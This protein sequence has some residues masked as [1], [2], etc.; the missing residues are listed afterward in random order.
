MHH[1]LRQVSFLKGLNCLQS[2][3][4]Q[5]V[6]SSIKFGRTLPDCCKRSTP[7]SLSNTRMTLPSQREVC[8]LVF[9]VDALLPCVLPH[10]RADIWPHISYQLWCARSTASSCLSVRSLT[11]QRC[12]L[13]L[14]TLLYC[15]DHTRC[16]EQ[17]VLLFWDGSTV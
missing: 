7:S 13:S 16:L 12:H 14:P 5:D 17:F 6:D 9:S 11:V 2:C 10:Q 4:T 15:A 3:G 8:C 1:F